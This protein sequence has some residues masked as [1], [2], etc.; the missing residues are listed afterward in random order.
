MK[1][2]TP[3]LSVLARLV[4]GSFGAAL[5]ALCCGLSHPAI[6]APS[7]RAAAKSAPLTLGINNGLLYGNQMEIQSIGIPFAELL[8]KAT[9]QR[10]T[11]NGDF[12]AKTAQSATPGEAFDFAFIK[13]PALT[14]Q[15]L[16]KG[17]HLVAVA[18]DPIGFGTD[19]IAQPCPGKP[20]QV[21]LGGQSLAILALNK[22]ISATCVPADKVWSSPSA[23]LLS[24]ENSLVEHVGQKMWKEHSAVPPRLAQVQS[25][26]AVVGLMR[27][28]HV[29]VVGAVTPVFSKK[30][31]ASGGV[32]LQHQP[33][34]FWA[35]LA[36]PDTSSDQ[37]AAV[38]SALMGGA[39]ERLNRTLKIPG[40]EAGSPKAYADFLKWLK[41]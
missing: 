10:A 28:M 6:A 8:D 14:A 13:P 29:A 1:P 12:N 39:S 22:Q 35:V 18:K 21:A 40:W 32:L 4:Q 5:L 37:I 7:T 19:L 34:P 30:W 36:A 9:G 27:D 24:V 20:G 38:R 31:V 33:M 25:Q 16:A 41:S 26:D 15:L 3:P 23:V 2:L 11:W 17:W